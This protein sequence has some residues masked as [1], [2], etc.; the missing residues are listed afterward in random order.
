MLLS[1]SDT[2]IRFREELAATSYGADLL[3]NVKNVNSLIGRV[4][5]SFVDISRDIRNTYMVYDDDLGNSIYSTGYSYEIFLAYILREA[6]AK[7]II[8]HYQE[9]PLVSWAAFFDNPSHVCDF[10]SGYLISLFEVGFFSESFIKKVLDTHNKGSKYP[11]DIEAITRYVSG[12]WKN[13]ALILNLFRRYDAIDD[14]IS[15]VLQQYLKMTAKCC[16]SKTHITLITEMLQD[17]S[18]IKKYSFY[19]YDAFVCLIN[20]YH[21]IDETSLK[22]VAKLFINNWAPCH[23]KD[24]V[25]HANC[26]SVYSG[27]VLLSLLYIG[28]QA[29]LEKYLNEFNFTFAQNAAIKALL[30]QPGCYDLLRR[31]YLLQKLK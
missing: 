30:E 12:L 19:M 7:F 11:T 14:R 4:R 9:I 23:K 25:D 26:L 29:L 31:H 28:D 8:K 13:S 20:S 5:I 18:A 10:S 2:C 27:N 3:D 1:E 17:T 24:Y 21:K 6:S 16:F 22:K 15:G